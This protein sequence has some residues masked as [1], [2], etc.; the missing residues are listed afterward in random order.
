T[1]KAAATSVTIADTG[2]TYIS[3]NPAK[4]V[5][6][7]EPIAPQKYTSPIAVPDFR[8][9]ST[10]ILATTGPIIPS[11]VPGTRKSAVTTNTVRASQG[12][13][14]RPGVRPTTALTHRQPSVRNAPSA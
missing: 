4:N 7:I 11:T 6:A 3:T 1:A 8:E 10:A 12:R 14:S 5:P 13:A 9:C 2:A